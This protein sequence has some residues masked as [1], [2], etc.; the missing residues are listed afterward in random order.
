MN[1]SDT[2]EYVYKFDLIFLVETWTNEKYKPNLNGYSCIQKS[3]NKVGNRGRKSGG[4]IVY[5]KI[6]G[7]MKVKQIMNDS[8]Q[9]MWIL[10][11]NGRKQYLFAI[12]YNPPKYSEYQNSEFFN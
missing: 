4:I 11:Q 10:C 12:L 6:Q 7:V 8:K 1:N 3:A 2:K 5:F 9:T